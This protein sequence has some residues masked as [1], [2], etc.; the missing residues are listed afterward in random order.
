MLLRCIWISSNKINYN[1]VEDKIMDFLISWI[2]QNAEMVLNVAF[3]YLCFRIIASVVVTIMVIAIFII[4]AVRM[5]HI[6][7]REY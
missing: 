1:N 4:T 2:N 3:W 6:N 5:Y 7:H